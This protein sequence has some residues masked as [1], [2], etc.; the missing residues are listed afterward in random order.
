[1]ARRWTLWP[2]ESDVEG[3]DSRKDAIYSFWLVIIVIVAISGVIKT[4]VSR[5]PA[6]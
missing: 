3:E 6:L 1:M 2:I 4:I 5:N